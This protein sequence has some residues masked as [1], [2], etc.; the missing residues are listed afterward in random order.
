LIRPILDLRQ[1]SIVECG[2]SE[3][4]QKCATGAAYERQQNREERIWELVV[5]LIQREGPHVDEAL[6]VLT[7]FDVG[8]AQEESDAIIDRGRR[9]LP[10]IDKYHH[11][12]PVIPYRNYASGM[13]R[14]DVD[15]HFEALIRLI[16]YA[17]DAV[18]QTASTSAR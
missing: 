8:V 12:R 4:T 18:R 7:C 10:L 9:M 17:S 11:C 14:G 3:K 13:L 15:A 16:D 6:V 5:D 1:R 2:T